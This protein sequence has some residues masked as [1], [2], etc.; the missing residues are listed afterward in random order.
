MLPLSAGQIVVAHYLII[1]LFNSVQAR[2]QSA[3]VFAIRANW[4]FLPSLVGSSERGRRLAGPARG[5][6]LELSGE[7]LISSSGASN[8][9]SA[10]CP[11]VAPLLL[12][13]KSF[14]TNCI[15]LSRGNKSLHFL[16][17]WHTIVANCS[18]LIVA[19]CLIASLACTKLANN[20]QLDS[21][22]LTAKRQKQKRQQ[23]QQLQKPEGVSSDRHI[24]H[25]PG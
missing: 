12:L 19:S 20:R 5:V 8:V 24:A 15:H 9:S 18:D 22:K 16:S 2:R 10:C 23:V 7:R 21:P 25:W 3:I 1:S 14:A 6:A 13:L 4:H 11:F 17:C